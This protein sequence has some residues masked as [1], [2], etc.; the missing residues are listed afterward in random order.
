M[1]AGAIDGEYAGAGGVQ[2]GYRLYP[3]AGCKTLI[4]HFHGN[5]EL[6]AEG[7]VGRA[8]R[9]AGIEGR[10]E[11]VQAAGR[12]QELELPGVLAEAGEERAPAARAAGEDVS[13]K[14]ESV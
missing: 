8:G 11:P 4:V 13:L 14:V 2:I 3:Q 12:D 5:A 1:H 10:G 9:E 6:A 7:G